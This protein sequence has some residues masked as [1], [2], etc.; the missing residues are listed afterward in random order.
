MKQAFIR[1]FLLLLAY[2]V[3]RVDI[4]KAVMFSD[5]GVLN[6]AP[7]MCSTLGRLSVCDPIIFHGVPIGWY[8]ATVLVSLFSSLW[9]LLFQSLIRNWKLYLLR[10][11]P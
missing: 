11:A 2:L 4:N 5:L 6:T 10:Y 3:A 7:G 8:F 9:A 1:G